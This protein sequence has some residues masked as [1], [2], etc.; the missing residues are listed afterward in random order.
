MTKS[1]MIK[2]AK[3]KLHIRL[4]GRCECGAYLMPRK[5]TITKQ[6]FL[7]CSEYPKCEKSYPFEKA[8]IQLNN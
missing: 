8:K 5:N 1:E 6:M 2:Q 4:Y 3:E 7:L